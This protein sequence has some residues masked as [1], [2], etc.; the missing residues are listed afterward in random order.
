[1]TRVG[2]HYH[3]SLAFARYVCG[4]YEM[5]F[6]LQPTLNSLFGFFNQRFINLLDSFDSYLLPLS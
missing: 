1:M 2:C 4:S 6:L 3:L 5:I